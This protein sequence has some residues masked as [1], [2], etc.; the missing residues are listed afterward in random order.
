MQEIS[1]KQINTRENSLIKQRIIQYLNL[2]GITLYAFYQKSGITR[3]ILSQNNGLSEDNLHKF[4]AYAQDISLSWLI[5]G[6]GEMLQKNFEENAYPKRIPKTHTQKDHLHTQ[7]AYPKGRTAATEDQ[8]L[9]DLDVLKENEEK[10]FQK[11][12]NP[13]MSTQ[14]VN[15]KPDFVNPKCQPKTEISIHGDSMPRHYHGATFVEAGGIPLIPIEAAAGI[16]SG[17]NVQVMDYECDHYVIPA[18]HGAD[19]L[20]R[21]AGDS[22]TPRYISG[23]LVA[24][25]RLAMVDF[26]QWNKSYII[27][28]AQGVLLKRVKRS[29]KPDHL[30]LVS[31]NEEYDPFEIPTSEIRGLALVVGLIRIE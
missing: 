3:N 25:I 19:F 18:F 5:F 26:L 1:T 20:I 4:L 12:V 14:N 28:S 23:D 10:N 16:L 24:C 27:D 6:Q 22:M 8:L 31:E 9:S 7:T 15:P 11:N 2:K 13:K 29:E 21:V 30:L 17:D